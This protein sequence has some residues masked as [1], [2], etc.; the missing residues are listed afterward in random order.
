MNW[1]DFIWF[2]LPAALCW[3]SAGFAALL[4][5]RVVLAHLLMIAGIVLFAVFIAGI[6]RDLGRPPLRTMGETRL[7]YAFFLAVAGYLIFRRWKYPWLL[8]SSGMMASLFTGINILRPEIHFAALAPAL[9]SPYFI[10]HVTSYILSYAILFVAT[11]TS[12]VI[13]RKERR[14][15]ADTELHSV[16][17]NIV[18]IG[19]GFLLFGLIT[20]ALWAKEAWGHYWSWDPKETWAFITAAAYLTYIHL[21][22]RGGR[23]RLTLW[24]PPVAFTLLVIAWAGVSYLPAAQGSTHVY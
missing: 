22:L 14:G 1:N 8:L 5:K 13:M 23:S 16:M 9:Q 15:K 2:S 12:F 20:G 6:W 21:R 17:D 24:L 10:P 7:W 18:Y 3:L 4:P 19:F 11:V